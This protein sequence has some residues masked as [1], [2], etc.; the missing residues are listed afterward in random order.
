ML[1]WVST[2]KSVLTKDLIKLN[3]I[4]LIRKIPNF[5][6]LNHLKDTTKRA[7]GLYFK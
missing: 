6:F 3:S 5:I 2:L 7:T 1:P 4:L